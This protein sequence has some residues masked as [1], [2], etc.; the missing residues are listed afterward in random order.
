MIYQHKRLIIV[1]TFF[2]Y[3]TYLQVNPSAFAYFF[4]SLSPGIFSP[5]PHFGIPGGGLNFRMPRSF[6]VS[7]PGFFTRGISSIDTIAMPYVIRVGLPG[8]FATG[9]PNGFPINLGNGFDI[10]MRGDLRVGA[11]IDFNCGEVKKL[12]LNIPRS[13]GAGIFGGLP[14]GMLGGFGGFNPFILSM[15]GFNFGRMGQNT[16]DQTGFSNFG[17]IGS[18]DF[19]PYGSL[20]DPVPVNSSAS[21]PDYSSYYPNASLAKIF[22]MNGY[23]AESS[24]ALISDTYSQNMLNPKGFIQIAH[25]EDLEFYLT[26]KNLE[27]DA[28]FPPT[29]SI[30]QLP[31]FQNQPLNVSTFRDPLTGEGDI[32]IDNFEYWDSPYNHGWRQIEPPYPV[33]GYAVGYTTI[34]KT[35]SDLQEGSRVLDVYRPPSVFLL[36]TSYEKHGIFYDLYTP[37]VPDV[38][39]EVDYI[40]L[41]DYPIVSFKFRAPLG[42]DPWDIFEFEVSALTNKD[43]EVIIRIKPVQSP[44][45]T[46]DIGGSTFNMGDYQASIVNV[47]LPEGPMIIEVNIGRNYLDGS[48]HVVWLDL[49]EVVH[50]AFNRYEDI[51]GKLTESDWE[52]VKADRIKI[53]GQMFRVDDI[54]FRQEDFRRIDQPD[55]FEPGPRYAQLFEPYRYLF[56]SDYEAQGNILM[57]SDFLLEPENFI[58]D[59]NTIRDIW[60][61][62]LLSL[63]PNYHAID[64]AHSQY[65]PNYTN[66]WTPGSPHFRVPDPVAESYLGDGFFIDCTLPVFADPNLRVGGKRSHELQNHGTL[67]W[68][69]TAGG[70]RGIQTIMIQPLPIDPYDGMPTYLPSYYRTTKVINVYGKPH[71]G[72]EQCLSLESALW[73]AGVRLW[74]NIAYI[75][76]EPQVFEDLIITIKVTNGMRSDVRTIPISVVNYPVD[77]YPPI[78]QL[79]ISKRIFYIGEK[80]EYAIRFLDPDCFIFSLA[81][82]KGRLPST[83]HLPMLPGNQIRRDQDNLTYSMTLHGLPSYQYGP[84]MEKIID[85]HSSL[86]SFVPQFEGIFDAVVTCTDNLGTYAFGEFTIYTTDPHGGIWL[87]HPPLG[88]GNPTRPLII[89]AGE[90]VLITAPD[91]KVYDID[92]DEL[93]ASCNIGSVGRTSDGG[94]LWTFQTN[95]PG[96]YDVEIIFYDIRG[97][98]LLRR[99]TVIVEPWWYF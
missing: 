26:K 88:L 28:Q 67:G 83:S 12:G 16:F 49:R 65:D 30:V 51:F 63:D 4:P 5:F 19:T 53:I 55:M 90:S 24:D 69:V 54:I 94:F 84:W 46:R 81:Q 73:N 20:K 13:F 50:K 6:G 35:I 2:I 52:I 14:F 22:D 80:N 87:N 34:F 62:D 48:W 31:P 1:I 93:Y 27:Q 82:F 32:L 10:S 56:M 23:W 21:I 42:I 96:T 59:P 38:R 68:N 15:G 74:P 70:H 44:S 86:I 89:K 99:Y 91:L 76:Y 78:T 85:P 47:D 92:G 17:G 43:C 60:I 36:G 79:H 7:G 75:D 37:L 33:Y 3:F 57:V 66:R 25:S 9:G 40:D 45:G 58:T 71:Y 72:P 77:N 64:P 18:F 95:S 29:G 61:S 41:V 11:S 98:Y 39:S 8:G 97:G